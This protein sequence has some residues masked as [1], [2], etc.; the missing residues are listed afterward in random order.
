MKKRDA[1]QTDEELT[2]AFDILFFEFLL[3]SPDV[4]DTILQEAG[5]NPDEVVRQM[6]TCAKGAWERSSL[7]WRNRAR[8]EV[9]EEQARLT[10]LSEVVQCDRSGM[11]AAIKQLLAQVEN[12]QQSLAVH[13]RKLEQASDDDLASL[14]E[15]LEYLV[16]QGDNK[17]A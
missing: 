13:F 9:A 14:L 5:Y 10:D 4:V 15:E 2:Q 7:N 1:P 8:K 17:S 6:R 16:G 11:I 12:K 3:E